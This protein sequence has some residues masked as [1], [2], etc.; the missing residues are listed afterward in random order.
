M[1]TGRLGI[2]KQVNNL[3][4]GFSLI[5][6][7]SPTLT[8]YGLVSP[9]AH[10]YHDF[11]GEPVASRPT[12]IALY[13]SVGRV[14]LQCRAR[15]HGTEYYALTLAA[16]PPVPGSLSLSLSRGGQGRAG[17]RSILLV[18]AGRPSNSLGK[19]VVSR[20]GSRSHTHTHTARANPLGKRWTVS[21]PRSARGLQAPRSRGCPLLL[22]ARAAAATATA[23][24]WAVAGTA[25]CWVCRVGQNGT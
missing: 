20:A 19:C 6:L 13:P 4:T 21:W 25:R 17:A 23:T 1:G 8:G 12:C 22:L 10:I 2:D 9:S 3:T 16:A 7:G 15:N 18:T 24:G 5:R 14:G 11:D